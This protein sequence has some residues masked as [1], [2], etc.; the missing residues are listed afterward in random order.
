MDD[1]RSEVYMAVC[2]HFYLCQKKTFLFFLF[3][4]QIINLFVGLRHVEHTAWF[5]WVLLP[6][7]KDNLSSKVL[8]EQTGEK[9]LNLTLT[10]RLVWSLIHHIIRIIVSL[11]FFIFFNLNPSTIQ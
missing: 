9:H 4:F 1:G 10:R 6:E 11:F 2:L 3:F 5:T 7:K 8:Y